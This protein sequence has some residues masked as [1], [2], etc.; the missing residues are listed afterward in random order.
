M[1]ASGQNL[2]RFLAIAEWGRRHAPCGSLAALPHVL[3]VIAV[4]TF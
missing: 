4:T 2:K 3:R 1:I